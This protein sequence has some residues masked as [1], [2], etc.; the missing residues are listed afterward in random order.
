MYRIYLDQCEMLLKKCSNV[1]EKE[2]KKQIKHE[3]LLIF[4]YL[5]WREMRSL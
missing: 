1:T 2:K 5:Y 3:M 4:E